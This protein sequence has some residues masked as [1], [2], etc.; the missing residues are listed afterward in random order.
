MEVIKR[1]VGT[2]KCTSICNIVPQYVINV[3]QNGFWISL[4]SYLKNSTNF[5]SVY[6]T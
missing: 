3:P 4:L 2:S 5:V 1:C 6:G